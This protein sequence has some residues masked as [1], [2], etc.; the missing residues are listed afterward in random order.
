MHKMPPRTNRGYSGASPALFGSIRLPESARAPFTLSVMGIS[1]PSWDRDFVIPRL[2]VVGSSALRV[3]RR[4]RWIRVQGAV[5]PFFTTCRPLD[6]PTA[7]HGFA[8][9][10]DSFRTKSTA[11][12]LVPP[13]DSSDLTGYCQDCAEMTDRPSRVVQFHHRSRCRKTLR[14]HGLV[15]QR[16][17]GRICAPYSI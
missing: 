2:S 11:L 13:K 15:C 3:P 12:P 10:A 14:N 5:R 7:L 8:I 4:C 9:W 17:P 6:V 16:A 1:N